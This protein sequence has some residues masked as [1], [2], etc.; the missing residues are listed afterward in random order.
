MWPED[1]IQLGNQPMSPCTAECSLSRDFVLWGWWSCYKLEID[2]QGCMRESQNLKL[3][4]VTMIFLFLTCI[5]K[6]GWD[7]LN[8]IAFSS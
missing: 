2:F 5:W 6:R 8:I 1:I 4:Y 7:K 3:S